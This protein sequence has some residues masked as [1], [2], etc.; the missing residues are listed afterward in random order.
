[1]RG[2]RLVQG[3]CTVASIRNTK[4]GPRAPLAAL[5]ALL[6]RAPITDIMVFSRSCEAHISHSQQVSDRVRLANLKVNIRKC[7]FSNAKLDFLGQ[8]L[9]L[10]MVQPRQQKVEALLKFPVS[11]NKKQVQSLLG[12]AGY[13]RKFL[14]HFAD[15]TLSSTAML[16]TN[17][18][19][20]WSKAANT[21][22]VDLKSRLASRPILRPTNYD[23]PFSVEVDASQTCL[24]AV[25]PRL[26]TMWSIR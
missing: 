16:K 4:R 26:W 23:L 25:F 6:H 9:S 13:Y 8:T 1:M 2:Y 5:I 17:I 7:E 10:N 21:A 15:L 3:R 18:P 20:R 14:P 24:G 12:F 22:F 19:F 11:N